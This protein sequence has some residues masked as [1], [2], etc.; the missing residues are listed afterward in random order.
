MNCTA[1]AIN[2]YTDFDIFGSVVVRCPIDSVWE[3]V[4]KGEPWFR[5]VLG[6]ELIN[7]TTVSGDD[8]TL[9]SQFS[10]F[11]TSQSGG[12][13]GNTQQ[14]I[15]E[16]SDYN[17]LLVTTFDFS[18]LPLGP[19]TTQVTLNKV[20]YVDGEADFTLI[21][22]A[23]YGSINVPDERREAVRAQIQSFFGSVFA[24]SLKQKFDDCGES[25]P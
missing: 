6:E 15:I 17:Y 3:T 1:K 21:N 20:T 13:P 22:F 9:G 24:P 10:Y 19:W 25:M 5:I 23:Q 12:D 8:R 14:K 2:K 16:L 7:I 11:V 18:S 4:G